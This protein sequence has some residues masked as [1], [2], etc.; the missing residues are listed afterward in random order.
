MK[1]K[2]ERKQGE[3]TSRQATNSTQQIITLPWKLL[4]IVHFYIKSNNRIQ[5]IRNQFQ[6]SK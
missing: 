1:K 2:K 6:L 3:K 4:H 5:A